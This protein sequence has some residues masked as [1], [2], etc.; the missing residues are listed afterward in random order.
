MNVVYS[1]VTRP[2]VVLYPKAQ[3]ELMEFLSVGAEGTA[4][5]SPDAS[6]RNS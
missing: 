1:K 5:L 2:W 4:L 3:S 6:E